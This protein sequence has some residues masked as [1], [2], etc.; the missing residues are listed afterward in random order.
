LTPLLSTASP[1]LLRTWKMST[2]RKTLLQQHAN[3][4]AVGRS[5][6]LPHPIRRLAFQAAAKSG[7]LLHLQDALARKAAREAAGVTPG[8]KAPQAKGAA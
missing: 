7:V 4:L 6:A 8:A 2:D 1:A 3:A 5:P